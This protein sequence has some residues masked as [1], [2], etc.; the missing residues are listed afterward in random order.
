MK[1]VDLMIVI[2][3]ESRTLELIKA[4][5]EYAK[6]D[7]IPGEHMEKVK[8]NG[9]ATPQKIIMSKKIVRRNYAMRTS[10]LMINCILQSSERKINSENLRKH[11]RCTLTYFAP[12]SILTQNCKEKKRPY[13]LI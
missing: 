5:E 11:I 1:N 7:Y 6:F 13:T 9:A 4:C 8:N 10:K 12:F 3:G 2:K